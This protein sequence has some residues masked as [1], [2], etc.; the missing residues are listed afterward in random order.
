MLS[1]T[2]TVALVLVQTVAGAGLIPTSARRTVGLRARSLPVIPKTC[3]TDC[4][5][6]GPFFDGA[7]CAVTQ[8]CSAVFQMAYF[9]CFLCVG[10]ATGATDYTIAQD[11]VDVLTT[12]C[13]AENF[14]LPLLSL[15]GQDPN[16]TPTSV[17]PAG[18]SAIPV[19]PAEGSAS[20]VRRSTT[21]PSRTSTSSPAHSAT[22]SSS[23]PSG[24]SN[25][26]TAS[27]PSGASNSATA[28]QPASAPSISGSGSA[29]LTAPPQSTVTSPP[30]QSS[31]APSTSVPPSAGFRARA[32]L[33]VVFACAA[34]I[35]LQSWL[36]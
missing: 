15:P 17:L 21:T 13:I 34:F 4:A 31:A 28:S 14:T 7:A 30:S 22:A 24:A 11:Y 10:N 1:R 19:F 6:F 26:A 12:S 3:Q 23:Q 20:A 18:A 35:A 8:C 9:D 36:V 29:S 27:Q 33:E 2:L 16:R 5:P 32:P 25:S